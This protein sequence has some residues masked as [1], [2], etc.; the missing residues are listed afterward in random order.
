MI[1]TTTENEISQ[2]I[3]SQTVQT[4]RERGDIS[5]KN[6]N[7]RHNSATD[8]HDS[9]ARTKD[10]KLSELRAKELKLNKK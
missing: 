10:D 8:E 6:S 7:N 1:D 9:T 2:L 5:T 4:N 3:S